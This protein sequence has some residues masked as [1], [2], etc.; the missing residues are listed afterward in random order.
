[1]ITAENVFGKLKTDR[2]SCLYRQSRIFQVI[3][4]WFGYNLYERSGMILEK[5]CR[6]IS[7][8][9]TLVIS[10]SS[11]DIKYLRAIIAFLLAM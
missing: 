4:N 10:V 11:D 9:S 5:Y 3:N 2:I 7:Y 6:F 8:A 1:M